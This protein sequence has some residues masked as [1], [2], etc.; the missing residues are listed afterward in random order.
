MATTIKLFLMDGEATGRIK[1]SFSTW[2]CNGYKISASEI[3]KCDNID[4]LKRAGIYFLFGEDEDNNEV[5]YVGQG[6]IRQN[7]Q[8]VLYRIK[9]PHPQIP[10]WTTCVIFVSALIQDSIGPTELNYLEH[11]FTKLAQK[12]NRFVVKNRN[13][14][15]PANLSEEDKADMD[16]FVKNATLALNVL[17]F[18]ILEPLLSV[19]ARSSRNDN[20]LSYSFNG[21]IAKGI[22]TSE[23][24]VLLKGSELN[25]EDK[26]ASRWKN[27]LP[28]TRKKYADKIKNNKTIADILFKSSSGAANFCSGQSVS[29][30]KSWRNPKGIT[31]EELRKK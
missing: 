29:G 20:I 12:A 22:G 15:N 17:G 1:C 26:F 23:G 18:K 10:E 30:P 4:E 8:G 11:E 5:V 2:N 27:K 13:L 25:P 6:N 3:S 7:G 14:P 24:F 21:L 31:L 16:V 28:P 19:Q 9:E